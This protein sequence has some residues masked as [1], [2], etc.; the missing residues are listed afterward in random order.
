MKRV[1]FNLTIQ[2][3][4]CKKWSEYN[5]DVTD[6]FQNKIT[7]HCHLPDENKTLIHQFFSTYIPF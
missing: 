2:D 6:Y 1:A 7:K 3:L 4:L 5:Q